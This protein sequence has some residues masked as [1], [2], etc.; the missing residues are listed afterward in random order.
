MAEIEYIAQLNSNGKIP[1]LLGSDSGTTDYWCNSGYV[2]VQQNRTPVYT[3]NTASGTAR[4]VR[5]VY[6]DWYWGVSSHSR[7]PENRRG[8]FVWGDQLRSSVVISE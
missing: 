1:L 5:C 8:T 2:T 4:Y 3:N 7:L 6:D